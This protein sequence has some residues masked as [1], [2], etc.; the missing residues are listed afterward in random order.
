MDQFE[1]VQVRKFL[2]EKYRPRIGALE[3]YFGRRFADIRLLDVGIGYGLF[4]RAL[5]QA[6][7]EHLFGMDPH[8]K[9]I[10]IARRNT[11]AELFEGNILDDPWP[12]EEQGYD[13]IT[14][15]DV[16]EHLE[17]PAEFFIKVKRYIRPRGVALVTTPN[18]GIPYLM[19]AIPIIGRK[20]PNPTHINVRAPRYWR[21]LAR[22][23]GYEIVE[24]WKGE[25]LTH[26]RFMP[27]VM[28]PFFRFLRID[29]RRIPVIN[30]F[31]QSY[32][33]LIRPSLS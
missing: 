17:E 13:A 15:L 11:S 14:C 6:G 4:L 10:E 21:R 31:E 1:S 29:H 22:E 20:D 3:R 7:L 5:E 25:H 12:A 32:C 27:R 2:D 18:K 26:V 9:S 28:T 16:V 19:R 33:M 24:E 8:P 30:A 23:H